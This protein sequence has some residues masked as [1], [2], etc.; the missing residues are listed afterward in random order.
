M[1][2]KY[3]PPL[4]SVII[5]AFNAETYIRQTL[6]SVLGQTYQHIEVLVV[7]DGSS[8]QTAEIVE[9]IAE[10]DSRIILFQQENSGVANARN[11]A[12]QE[13][14]GEYI[15]N[16]DADD[17]WYPENIEKQMKQMLIAG[18]TVGVVYS[19]SV[20]IDESDLL[21]GGFLSSNIEGE[22]YQELVYKYFLGNASA[23]LIRRAC[24]DKVGGYNSEFKKLNAQ[25]C[26][27]WDLHLRIAECYQ[28]RV[29]PEFLIQYRQ[30]AGS[31]STDFRT[32][33]RSHALVLKDVFTRHPETHPKIYRWSFSC[34]H[35]RLAVLSV[36][37]GDYRGA[38]SWLYKAVAMDP[39][40][41]FLNH[42]LYAVLVQVVATLIIER[43]ASRFP[44]SSRA[45][46]KPNK[47]TSSGQQAMMISYVM[48]RMSL[49]SLLPSQ[50]Y[51][52]IRLMKLS[53]N[54]GTSRKHA[55]I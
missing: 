35:M 48:R 6:N 9:S 55:M 12:I 52:R 24:P 5:A 46:V 26:E 41:S 17:I 40:M 23:S 14:R 33:A 8:D 37:F 19:W 53:R 2:N 50:V 43:C 21:T 45:H 20:E 42:N 31:M 38:L 11:L 36:R 49:H 34:F 27:D 7:D 13:A 15:A 39:V 30:K 28:F 4:V 1:I 10:R 18:P 16:I 29:V 54:K 25:G 22:V 44:S 3:T 51:E 32:M 47:R